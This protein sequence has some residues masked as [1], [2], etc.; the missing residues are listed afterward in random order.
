LNASSG[1]DYSN[2]WRAYRRRG[3][4]A[5]AALARQRVDFAAARADQ[6]A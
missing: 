3:E 2:R 1:Q 6:P 4:V 5:A